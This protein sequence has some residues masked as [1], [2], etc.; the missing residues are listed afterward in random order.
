M[1]SI[2]EQLDAARAQAQR[3]QQSQIRT[4]IQDPH[5]LHGNLNPFSQSTPSR[6]FG[7]D[8]PS[9]PNDRFGM[10]S[11]GLIPTLNH[12]GLSLPDP[13]P[14]SHFWSDEPTGNAHTLVSSFPESTVV[15]LSTDGVTD[16]SG[17]QDY[18]RAPMMGSQVL[19]LDLSPAFV[20]SLKASAAEF[21]P[22]LN[23]ALD[24][25]LQTNNLAERLAAHFMSNLQ[26]Q[27]MIQSL[28]QEKDTHWEVSASLRKLLA[29][30]ARA[31]MLSSTAKFYIKC[32]PEDI[33]V[34]A[35]RV[36]RARDL[37]GENDPTANDTLKS[38][39]SRAI[40]QYR[41]TVKDHIVLTVRS[42][43]KSKQLPANER[44]I[45]TVAKNL[46]SGLKDVPLS[47]ALMHRLAVMRNV[48]SNNPDISAR[49]FWPLVDSEMAN[50]LGIGKD[51]PKS[52][53]EI[54]SDFQFIYDADLRTYGKPQ[55]APTNIGSSNYQWMPYIKTLNTLAGNASVIDSVEKKRKRRVGDTGAHRNR[56]TASADAASEGENGSEGEGEPGSE[57]GDNEEGRDDVQS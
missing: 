19:N 2:Q 10:G 17:L 51:H 39:A 57:P 36:N 8:P 31:Y 34:A 32:N 4:P 3:Q 15:N 25:Y 7:D 23:D 43:S 44:D 55:V 26:T 41:S 38:S 35:L 20:A 30:Y 28:V 12:A 48:L 42:T 52:Q 5:R 21:T 45:A 9:L 46:L 13:G 54:L 37:P 33:I 14:E 53:Q 40:V 49:D 56:R 24:R 1:P 50:L 27:S 6:L 18:R 47:L 11:S 16:N 29:K 22:D